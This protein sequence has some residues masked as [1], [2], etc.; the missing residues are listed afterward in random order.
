MLKIF[1]MNLLVVKIPHLTYYAYLRV[2][3]II[4]SLLIFVFSNLHI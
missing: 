2:S 1:N 4:C 3:I